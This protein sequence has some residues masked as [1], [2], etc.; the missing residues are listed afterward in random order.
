MSAWSRARRRANPSA[1]L[2]SRKERSGPNWQCRAL[3]RPCA[4]C[5]RED[6]LVHVTMTRVGTG[7]Q[8]IATATIVGEEMLRWLRDLDGFV[9]SLM[10]S[11][12]GTTLS[13]TFWESAEAAERHRAAR[14]GF[15]ERITTVAGVE[16]Q[17]VEELE[18]TFAQLAALSVGT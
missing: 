6:G 3:S 4:A 7:E 18:V 10:L 15:R 16:I 8:P 2:P 9:G 5:F 13:L 17:E 11:R 12:A 14:N 1:P